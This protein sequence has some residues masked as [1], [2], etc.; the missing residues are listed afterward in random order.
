MLAALQG[1]PTATYYQ[2]LTGPGTVFGEP[3]HPSLGHGRVALNRPWEATLGPP[4]RL[5][6]LSDGA[7]TLLVVEAADPVPWTK[8]ADRPFDPGLVEKQDD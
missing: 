5:A 1:D 2:V 6:D 4:F 8:P 7:N 3:P